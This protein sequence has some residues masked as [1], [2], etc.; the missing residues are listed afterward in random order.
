MD[1]AISTLYGVLPLP[2]PLPLFPPNR[3]MRWME[4]KEDFAD[5]ANSCNLYSQSPSIQL[6]HLRR[7]LGSQCKSKFRTICAATKLEPSEAADKEAAENKVPCTLFRAIVN[8]FEL[9]YC[10]RQNILA[11]REKFYSCKQESLDANR[12]IERVCELAEDCEFKA[13]A[14]DEM[15]RDRLVFGLSSD[16]L[17]DKLV[18]SE[19]DDLAYVIQT[20]RRSTLASAASS[21]AGAAMSESE[22]NVNR[23]KGER[24]LDRKQRRSRDPEVSSKRCKFCNRRHELVKRMCP[25]KDQ[26]CS[27]CHRVGHFAVCC[28]QVRKLFSLRDGEA[29]SSET[30]ATAESE[31]ED[32]VFVMSTGARKRR[33]MGKV[34]LKFDGGD[35]ALRVQIDSGATVDVMPYSTFLRLRERGAVPD[36]SPSSRRLRMYNGVYSDA[37]GQVSVR[38]VNNSK[39]SR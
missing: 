2:A 3:R 37:I 31:D 33:L 10:G 29:S 9:D 39:S 20:I 17:R 14:K 26:K 22:D 21:T 6:S 5:Y 12:F 32:S 7:A 18:Q 1:P 11:N 8:A 27:S 36:L 13:E 25:A 34:K 24:R 23:V 28:E 19:R 38:L 4:F 16:R 15:V 35:C 30:E